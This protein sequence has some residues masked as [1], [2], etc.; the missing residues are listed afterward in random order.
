MPLSAE[1]RG[2]QEFQSAVIRLSIW[3]FMLA[4]LW[5]ARYFGDYDFTWNEY[6]LLF[7]VH[8]IWYGGLLVST[9]VH[10]QL[11]S[12]R[13]YFSIIA[14][15]SGTTWTLYM[16]GDATGPFYLMYA[17][18]FLSQG[19]R[20]GKTNLL[21]A[22]LCSLVAFT[23]VAAMLGDWQTQTLEVVF[24]ALVL[25]VLPLYEYSLLR[26]LQLA[27]QVAETANRARGD[28]LATMTHELRTPL[29]G[30]IGMSGLLQRTRLDDEQRDY[31]E[32][33]NT[34]A[35]VLQSLIG[36]ILD[37]SKIDAGKLELKWA[38]FTLRDSLNETCWALSNQALDKGIELVCRVAA[39]LPDK[40]LGDELRFR[41]ILFNLIGNAVKFTEQGHVLVRASLA[42]PDDAVSEPHLYVSIEDTGIGIAADRVDRV[43][44]NFWQADPSSTRRY[45]GTGL[46]TAI[47]RDLTRLM[48][49]VIGVDS[50]ENEGSV[51]WV[52]LPFLRAPGTRPPTPPAVLSG[53]RALVFEQNDVSAA[54][55]TAV[56]TA[57]GMDVE[58]VADIEHLGAVGDEHGDAA[59]QPRIVLVV[60]AP[61]GLDLDRVG[62]L[63]RRLL[64]VDT[65]MVYL[66]YPRRKMA[67]SDGTAAR[68]F[69][70]ISTVQLWR[71]MAGVL[72]VGDA[73]PAVA[74]AVDSDAPGFVDGA[75]DVTGHVLVAE[76]DDINA[77]LIESLLR[78]AGC[79]VTL[80]RDGHAA[81][82]AAASMAFDLAFIDLRMP[83]MDGIHF[84]T[85]YRQRETPG[86]HLPIIALTAN[87]AEDARA[88]C[89]RAG[90]DDFV[91][92]PVDPQLLQELLL[93]YG[94]SC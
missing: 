14:D 10:P 35:G 82:D 1:I 52:R 6:L 32:S 33:I 46:G 91:T 41:Q 34:S 67:F 21:I 38:P 16:T 39:D 50:R 89:L 71:A 18:S 19:M 54:A 69:K 60:D 37:L 56:C 27:K 72:R 3:A 78:K 12:A 53:V 63:V 42:A 55:I 22:S 65:P 64:G 80:V 5:L 70:P 47:A 86:S 57:A 90:M 11:W 30:V 48:G 68:A 13:T 77:R 85:E 24:V 73:R 4:M 20:Y 51:F 8:L 87:A 62:N 84:T 66:H 81:L 74:N 28:F 26:R 2:S 44:D 59:T 83:R 43:F 25:I 40:V 23:S 45:G 58:V 75:T 31:V 29:S 79:R 88:E 7:G 15:L 76:D 92:K 17:V 36:D 94:V 9:I 61:R 49:G 93:R